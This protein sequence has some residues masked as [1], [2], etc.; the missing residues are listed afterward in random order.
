MLEIGIIGLPNVGK[1]T[2]FNAL[3]KAHAEV[4]NYPFA[5]IDK[6]IGV[7][8]VPDPRLEALLPVYSRGERIPKSTPTTI[9]F[10]DIAGLVKGASRGEGLGN[11]F[12]AHIR[13]VS[14]V[15][16]VVRCFEDPDI[17]HVTGRVDPINDIATIHTEL[18]LA[19]I[20]TLEKRLER[21]RRSAKASKVDADLVEQCETV[22]DE[23]SAGI[24]AR[25][26]QVALPQEF[27]L[28]TAKPVI[29]I[30]NV[31]EADLTQDNP[32]LAEVHKVAADEGAEVVVISAKIEQELTELS[33]SDAQEFLGDLGIETT[34]LTRLI[35]KSYAL[36]DLLT[37][38][39]GNTKEI[40]AWTVTSGTKAPAAAGKIHTDFERGFIRAEVIEWDKAVEAGSISRAKTHGW[41]R[42]EG[43]DYVVKDGDVIQFL[44]SV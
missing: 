10:I 7:V 21:L 28:L 41:V 17:V 33:E 15:A 39:S 37:F 35:N 44:F 32:Y 34:G 27:P 14:A 36:L 19:D 6:N 16:H 2:I 30:C 42:T 11:Q 1:S 20:G 25:N 29:Y 8:A 12:L 4:A 13:E 23:L 31:S 22:I 43:K 18:A 38:F 24:P 9:E 5:T 26:S 3:T 40:H